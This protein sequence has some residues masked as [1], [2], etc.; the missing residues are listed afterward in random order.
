MAQSYTLKTK[1]GKIKVSRSAIAR[2][3]VDSLDDMRG[4]VSMSSNRGKLLREGSA[5]E[6]NAVDVEAF[7]GDIRIR[8]NVI[9]R[10]GV[11][12]TETAD[13]IAASVQKALR[14]ILGRGPSLVTIRVRGVISQ[15]NIAPRNIT[16]RRE[17]EVQ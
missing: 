10:F 13:A 7:E 15:K 16:I 9:V 14:R 6:L 2:A 4:K 8:V 1:Y 17:L 12:I 3:V 5:A 11:S